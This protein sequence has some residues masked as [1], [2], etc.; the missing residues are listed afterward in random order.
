M[1]WLWFASLLVASVLLYGVSFVVLK[2]RP[3]RNEYLR[4]IVH[5]LHCVWAVAIAAWIG[6]WAVIVVEIVFSVVA[7][8]VRHYGWFKNLRR[9]G[10]QS[11][12][13]FFLPLGIIL[14]ASLEPSMT[15]F[16]AAMAVLGIADTMAALVGK[17]FIKR[18][19]FKV[20]G[21]TK[22]IV[23]SVVFWVI[24]SAIVLAAYYFGNLSVEPHA[25]FVCVSLPVLLTGLEVVGIYGADNLVLPVVTVLVLSSLT[26]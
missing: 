2:R 11:Y 24:S 26:M 22:T 14:A 17:H 20:F 5:F 18:Y 6:Y 7:F 15:V 4:K 12:G 8:V 10:R 19:G 23:G 3:L 16:V 21:Q 25:L 9:V 1:H 13:E